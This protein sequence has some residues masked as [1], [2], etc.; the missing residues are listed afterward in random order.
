MQIFE[1][2]FNPR[3]KEDRFFSTFAYEPENMYEK[4]LGNLYAVAELKN[5]LPSNSKLPENLAKAAKERYYTFSFKTQ[6][7]A[8]SEA[9]KKA[10][11]FLTEEVKKENVSWLENLNFA[12]LSINPIRNKISNGAG[13][14]DLIFTK[15]GDIKILLLRAGRIIDIGKN[16]DLQE[17]DPYPLKIFFNIVQGQLAENDLLLVVTKELYSFFAREKILEKISQLKSANPVRSGVSNEVN[18]KNLKGIFSPLYLQKKETPLISGICFLVSFSEEKPEGKKILL[19]KK[20]D[21]FFSKI[22]DILEKPLKALKRYSGFFKKYG[23]KESKEEIAKHPVPF[24]GIL[25][26]AERYGIKSADIKKQLILIVFLF[27]FLLFG[28]LMFKSSGLKNNSLL[29]IQEMAV[30]AQ[31]LLMNSEK[32]KANEILKEAWKKILPLTKKSKNKEIVALKD[33]LQKTLEGLNNLERIESP[34]LFY[35]LEADKIDFQPEKTALI[36]D[37]LYLYNPSSLKVFILNLQEKAGSSFEAD[38]NVDFILEAEKEA[39]L[40]SKPDIISHFTE[41]GWQEV[42]IKLPENNFSFDDSN[43]YFSDIYFLDGKKCEIVKYFH[44]ENYE[45]GYSQPWV[46]EKKEGPCLGIKSMKV[47]GEV[48]LLNQDNSTDSYY[49]GNYQKTLVLNTFPFIE[50]I[51]G[52]ETLSEIPYLY[53]LEPSQKRIIIADKEGKIIKQILSEKFD[54][55]KDFAIS[56][57]GKIIWVLNGLKI[58]QINL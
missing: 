16:L 1:F 24:R 14:Y 57:D 56:K 34:N 29:D 33:S 5:A 26:T 30:Q 18:D 43:S 50:N 45:W 48:W 39:V 13:N 41:E 8:A 31:Q 55:L 19:Q 32:E 15:T 9:L 6:E 38:R 3:A 28:Y 37:A 47:A 42:N 52:I 27:I 21:F 46:K 40:F 44:L 2:H 49:K 51:A 17:I 20:K 4:R 36:E 11:E 58:Y 54:D 35:E 7:R 25:T 10:N 12:L 23:K 53:L 22:Y